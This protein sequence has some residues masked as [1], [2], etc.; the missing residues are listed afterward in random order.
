M[1]KE[2]LRALPPAPGGIDVDALRSLVDRLA[3]TS[4]WRGPLR[5]VH[6]D[7]YARHLLVDEARR[8]CGVIDWGYVHLGDPA[9]DLSIAF[10]F[11]P[12]EARSA[13]RETYGPIDAATWD[14]ARI[15]ALFYGAGL[16][17]HGADVGD[18]AIRVA[19]GYALRAASALFDRLAV[20]TTATKARNPPSRI[21]RSAA[22][23]ME[24]AARSAPRPRRGHG[25]RVSL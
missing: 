5:W 18:N 22:G 3:T 20:E 2:R 14:R 24:L 16:V 9:L 8:P 15:R 19:G 6:G 11:L 17:D 10:S 12:A 7:L 21:Q 25:F 4:S 1:V 13:F 23:A